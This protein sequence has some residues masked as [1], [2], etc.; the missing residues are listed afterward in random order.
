MHS[1]LPSGHTA[2]KPFFSIW[3]HCSQATFSAKCWQYVTGQDVFLFVCFENW[4][5]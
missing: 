1:L 4:I 3:S 2:P 5:K